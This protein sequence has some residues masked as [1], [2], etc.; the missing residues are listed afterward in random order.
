MK[1]LFIFLPLFYIPLAFSQVYEVVESIDFD[2]YISPMVSVKKAGK[3][4][5]YHAATNIWVDD[6]DEYA[7]DLLVVIKDGKYGM[8]RD[9]GKLLI[10]II[11]DHIKLE[12]DYEGQWYEGIDYRYKFAVLQQNNKVGVANE[13]GELIVPFEYSEAKVINKAVIGVAI[14]GQWGWVSAATGEL[15]HKPEFEYL[16]KYYNEGYVEVRNGDFAGVAKA[17]GELI[18]P[19]EYDDYM[20]ILYYGKEVRFEGKIADRVHVFDTTGTELISG[21]SLYQYISGSDNL[22]FK[23]NSQFGIVDPLTKKV[24]LEPNLELING[25]V[26]NLAV[27]KKNGKYGVISSEGQQVLNFE[28]D[29]ISFLTAAG[30]YR[31]ESAPV[32]PFNAR[33][34]KGVD[35]NKLK[36][37]WDYEQEIDAQPYLIAAAKGDA[38]GVFKWQG[39]PIVP[40]GKY[41]NI[42]LRYFKGKTFYW[43]EN[44]NKWG[45]INDQGK[46]ILPLLY[47]FDESYQF[48]KVAV[49][50]D[51]L[52]FDRFFSF[53]NGKKEN[54]YREEIGLFDLD[55]QKLIIPIAE[56]NIEIVN[57]EHIKIR[58]ELSTYEYE[59]Y[60]YNIK[61]N[62]H[63]KLP[64]PALEYHLLD[65]G[66]WIAEMQDKT[67]KLIDSAG[68]I[69]YENPKWSSKEYYDLL[70]FPSYGSK[71]HGDFYHGLKKI[72]TSEANL[73]VNEKGQEQRFEEVDQV[74]AF[75]EGYAL[76]AKKGEEAYKYG[77]I[78]LKGNVI[79]PFEFDAV[80]AMGAESEFLQFKKGK[81]SGLVNRHGA[82]LLDPIYTYID[83]NSNYPY[84]IVRKDDKYGL[85]DITGE[86]IITPQY[87]ALR[88][89]YSG[90]DNT[91]PLIVTE[92]GWR[93]FM[94]S[95]GTKAL[96]KAKEEEY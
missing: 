42:D 76:A 4:Y 33:N 27:A 32:A 13:Q 18:I 46:E 58:K 34:I 3:T 61:E 22:V 90:K 85:A 10:P 69:V 40:V 50:D 14:D 67:Y 64:G 83:Y 78:D 21:H 44:D 9:D 39:E 47:A 15:V 25:F 94:N 57:T 20:R 1:Y 75:Y 86:I 29:E 19:V 49:N 77:M 80:N 26:R 53:S 45:I 95:D 51:N 23:E 37:R 31:S 35:I 92:K 74:D 30:R 7:A 48:S 91:W 2:N 73:F 6:V 66:F 11:Y 71:N 62:E 36:A 93:Y 54:S 63:N 88:R 5:Y 41:N 87:E 56:Q 24:I 68:N 72:Y 8:L 81:L 43:V 89:N 70:R 82:I 59:F 52:I 28:Y 96:I 55:L 84:I 38:K 79:V 65:N 17:N 60:D 16:S 12:T